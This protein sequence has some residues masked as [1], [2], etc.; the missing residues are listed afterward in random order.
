LDDLKDT[1]PIKNPLD[2]YKTLVLPENEWIYNP[3]NIYTWYKRNWIL[4]H[5]D[6]TRKRMHTL[7][8]LY[9]HLV[10]DVQYY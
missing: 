8:M 4:K 7:S 1:T 10:H 5:I 9:I 2:Y 3:Y 6:S